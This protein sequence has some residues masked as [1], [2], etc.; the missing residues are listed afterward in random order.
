MAGFFWRQIISAILIL[1]SFHLSCGAKS[2]GWQ[3]RTF[4]RSR[5][6][7]F[8]CELLLRSARID[9]V[10]VVGRAAAR[11]RGRVRVGVTPLFPAGAFS[12]DR[13]GGPKW[14]RCGL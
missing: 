12:A 8:F 7:D 10:R 4:S 11:S 2:T 6:S 13:R 14:L 5:C 3:L 1:L 9:I